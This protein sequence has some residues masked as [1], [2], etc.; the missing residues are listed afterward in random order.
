MTI[1][2]AKHVQDEF[3]LMLNILSNYTPKAQKYIEAKNKLLDN[4]K[5]F[6]KRREKITEGFK[7]GIFLLKDII[8][9]KKKLDTKKKKENIR[10]EN[11][12]IDYKKLMNLIYLKE[13]DISETF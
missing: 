2:H 13:I 11:G 9:L 5:N 12:L 1:D 7:N 4:A 3:N 6:Y 10:D 8:N